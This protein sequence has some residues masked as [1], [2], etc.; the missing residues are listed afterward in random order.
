[1]ITADE[2]QGASGNPNCAV[3]S[4]PLAGGGATHP[5][6]LQHHTISQLQQEKDKRNPERRI[7]LIYETGRWFYEAGP[8]TNRIVKQSDRTAIY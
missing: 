7:A 1:M 3:S 8:A 6:S 5:P 2:S 4:G